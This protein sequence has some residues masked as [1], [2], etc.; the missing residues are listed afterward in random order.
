M[1]N[2]VLNGNNRQVSLHDSYHRDFFSSI[3]TLVI[4]QVPLEVMDIFTQCMDDFVLFH[5]SILVQAFMK[6]FNVSICEYF[7][8]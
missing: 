7:Q 4:Q 1:F 2:I 6:L 5:S 8:F 3:L